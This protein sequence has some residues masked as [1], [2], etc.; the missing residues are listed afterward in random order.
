MSTA[1]YSLTS[2]AT[3]STAPAQAGRLRA[4]ASSAT[5]TRRATSPSTWPLLTASTTANGERA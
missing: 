1:G 2:T 3:P 5:T 4:A